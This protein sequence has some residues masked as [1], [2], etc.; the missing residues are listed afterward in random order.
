MARKPEY[1]DKATFYL[2]LE[3]ELLKSLEELAKTRTKGNVTSLINQVLERY[4]K[5]VKTTS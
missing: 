2:H 4:V 1:K 3:A 5:S